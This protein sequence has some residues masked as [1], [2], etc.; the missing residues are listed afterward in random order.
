MRNTFFSLLKAYFI[1]IYAVN[2]FANGQTSDGE[3]RIKL[4]ISKVKDGQ[5]VGWKGC[6]GGGWSNFSYDEQQGIATFTLKG[7]WQGI[8]KDVELPPGRYLLRAVAKSNSFA[9]KLYIE[10]LP[11][12]LVNIFHIAIGISGDF[13]QVQLPFYVDGQEKKKF[14]LGIARVYQDP[15]LHEAIV[16]VKEMEVIRLG[17]TVL[18]ENWVSKTTVSLIHG[19]ETL[20][21]I[22]RPD[23][24]GRVIFS[25]AMLGTE[26]WLM[27]QGGEVNLSYAGFPDFS[28]DGKYFHGGFRTPG[29]VIRTDGS[30]RYKNPLLNRPGGWSD[31]TLWLF[32]WEEKRLPEGSNPSDWIC[33]IRTN[34]Y[35]EFYN[36][37]TRGTYRV[38]FPSRDGWKII[39]YPSMNTSRGPKISSITYEVLVWQSDDRQ[40]IAISDIEG[41]NFRAFR[42]KSISKNPE[43]DVVY[44]GEKGSDPINAVW[45]KSGKNWTHAVDKDGTRYFAF[46]INRDN[47]LTD[48][49]PYQVW[50]L[51][52]S[53][54]DTRGLLRVIPTPGVKQIPES[55]TQAWKGDTWWNLAGGSPRSGDN[56]ILTLE[57][58]TLVHM[59]ALGMHSNFE[60]TVSVNCPY[61]K[62]VRFIGSYQK[63]DHVCWPDEFRRDRDY[64]FVYSEVVP[65]LPFIMI[66]LEHDTFWTVAAM[67]IVDADERAAA[68]IIYSVTNPSPDYT[69]VLY[70]SSMLTVGRPEYQR[71][72]AYIAVTRYPQ[73]PV[74]LRVE[75]NILV[76]DKP[77]YHAEIKGYNLYYSNKSGI[78]Y[79]KVNTELLTGQSYTISSQTKG[80]YVM[81]SVEHSG[82]ESRMFSNEVHIGTD[83]RYRYFYEAEEGKINKPMVPFFEPKSA[84][85]AY[86]IAVT[87]PELLY[88]KTLSEGLKGSVV[89]DVHIPVAGTTKLMVRT[90][91]LSRLECETY[92]TGWPE[93]VQLGKGSFTVKVDGQPIG[94][95][96]VSG[97]EWK[98][99]VLNTRGFPITAGKHKITIETGD[100]GIAADN[101]LLTNDVQFLPTGKSN[102][103]GLA[104]S[105]PSGLKAEDMVVQGEELKWGGYSVKPPYFKLVWNE[106]KAP[107]GVRY[108]N[109]YRSEN[110]NVD[111]SPAMLVG[112]TTQPV[113]VDCVLEERKTYY[114][115]VSAVDNWDNRSAGSQVLAVT[116]Q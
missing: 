1:I 7:N 3:F 105:V 67:N 56:A 89:L 86:G 23:R 64:A 17:D 110:P 90:R 22:S 80:F 8:T 32:P 47:Y 48:E 46:E 13:H 53:F 45:G 104:P 27:T 101:I 10:E 31:K 39:Q 41:N 43:N 95:I 61:Q 42:I 2:I 79:E 51:P 30:F 6:R 84:S 70:A 65:T 57:D 74:N 78:G 29:D 98:W 94:S 75:G 35:V 76:W 12:S 14:Q 18:P 88:K 112:S 83:S 44:P 38:S 116:I 68:K 103:P 115:K 5:P 113:F 109:I 21:K 26:L 106:S 108:Y 15:S 4:D 91:A 82:L 25:D 73:P 58:G 102:T 69:K 40:Q 99:G 55:T 63:L 87:D 54:T 62:T 59:S 96:E 11:L 85:N 33:P 49:N 20:K 34:K 114:Y 16:Q 24:P 107:Q 9:P 81:T 111:V 19:L 100:V 36:L 93:E 71:G 52:L 60:N 37:E 50:M 66:D 97:C 72:D 28:N 77:R 92:T